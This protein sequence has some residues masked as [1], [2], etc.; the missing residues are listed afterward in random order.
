MRL[1]ISARAIGIRICILFCFI[2]P[3]FLTGFHATLLPAEPTP[4]EGERDPREDADPVT[5]EANRREVQRI[6]NGMSPVDEMESEAA[7]TMPH[8]KVPEPEFQQIKYMT[9]NMFV[10]NRSSHSSQPMK[11]NRSWICFEITLLRLLSRTLSFLTSQML[12]S[13]LKSLM[14]VVRSIT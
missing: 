7:R 10:Q 4:Q 12:N 14:S 11:L 8:S 6:L 5:T 9:A 13:W 1:I 3:L 2:V